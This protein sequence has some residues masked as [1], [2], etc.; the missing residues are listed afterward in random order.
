MATLSE[1]DLRQRAEQL[2]WSLS[3]DRLPLL[4]PEVQRLLDA[5]AR[6]RTLPFDREAAPRRPLRPSDYYHYAGEGVGAGAEPVPT[7]DELLSASAHELAA[8]VKRR[9]AS[10]REI[11]DAY[12]ARIDRLQPV[13]NCFT[14]VLPEFALKEARRIDE[15]LA[16][17]RLLGPLAGVPI[18][19]KD[20]VDIG[21]VP[22]TAGA[23]RR[24]HRLPEWDAHVIGR[25]R[26]AGAVIVGKTALHEFAYGVTNNNAHYGPT[27][28]PW[29]LRRI[30]GGSSGGSA[31]AVSAGL[32][33]GAIGTDTGGSIRI[34]AALCGVVGIKPTYNRV[35]VE[36]IVPL[37]WSL[38]HVGPLTRTVADAALFLDVMAMTEG[39]TE[40]FGRIVSRDDPLEP[41]RIGV[42]RTFFWEALDGE[43]ERLAEDA[44]ETLRGL[45]V[46]VIECDLPY[47]ADAGRVAAVVMSAEATA[48]HEPT[49]R[50]MA[51]A[52]GDDVR[53]R[54]ERGMFLT[55]ADYLAGLRGL[56]LIEQRWA[57]VFKHIDALVMPTTQIA[58]PPIEDEPGAAP[59][60][61]LAMSVQL[62]RQTNPFNVSGLPAVSVP[63][64]FT[65]AGLPVG[66]QIVGESRMEG[67]VLRIAAAYERAT[68]WAARRPP[69]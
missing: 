11:A 34:P 62:T 50:A 64:G 63:C 13:L 37:S 48:Y 1:H 2:E 21:G 12:L 16:A 60:A 31:A 42:P 7:G 53:T 36:G 35:L 28:N 30:P 57:D 25:L 14:Q 19:V 56:H 3:P 47:A 20:L 65:G 8:K 17:G 43:V 24:F 44:L 55:A 40:S 9:E 4:L 26:Q 29:D 66:L 46:E 41:I 49:L 22:T 61:S 38:D 32:C 5:A 58:A 27:Y 23:H 33:A 45:G 39:T 68:G 18:A 69:L 59:A 15:D 51:A 10:A 52:Y 6:V 67:L 54:L